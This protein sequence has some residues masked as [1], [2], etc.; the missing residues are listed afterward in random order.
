M[1]KA[2][3][4]LFSGPQHTVI[5]L[6]QPAPPHAFTAHWLAP[7]ATRGLTLERRKK[8]VRLVAASGVLPNM[9]VALQAAG[10]VGG[11]SQALKA[12]AGAGQLPMCQWLWDNIHSRTEDPYD[13]FL[14]DDALEAAAAGGHRSVCEWLLAL[15]R[16][17]LHNR[18]M[19][20]AAKGGHADLAEWLI[21]QRFNFIEDAH[22]YLQGSAHGCDLPA[23]QRAWLRFGPSLDLTKKGGVLTSTFRCPAPDWAA[24]A[25]WLE[26]QG[27]PRVQWASEV[28]VGLPD[29]G[30]ALDRLIW[31][32]GRGYPAA[33]GL[34]S[35]AALY[36]NMVVLQYLL[37][38][39][40]ML[41]DAH[42]EA[43]LVE[44]AAA[45]GQ[46]AMLQA[47]HAAGLPLHRH[48]QAA[49]GP[50]ARGGHVH[51]QTWL[52]EALGPA[53]VVRSGGLVTAAVESG[54]MELLA[55]LRHHG[56]HCD[57]GAYTSA[58]EAGWEAALE[59]LAEQGCP[60]PASG[61][62][63]VAA[64]RNGDLATATCL[65]RL[66]VP[67]GPVGSVLGA[68]AAERPID[69]IPL[70]L[71]RWLLKEGCPVDYKAFRERVLACNAVWPWWEDEVLQ[72]L[73]EY[74]GHWHPSYDH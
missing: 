60:M 9:V 5:H 6:S 25:E 26:A 19:F 13:I 57:C 17:A 45:G 64:C 61:Q 49:A 18:A 48:V 69:P 42:A 67:W 71:L 52:L 54:S 29:D 66:G 33:A 27:C 68:G 46:L 51:V 32:L 35:R 40:P 70:P 74:R 10:F 21:P 63:Y 1:N 39:M 3:A 15:G 43:E 62:P 72:L 53:A 22:L 44:A 38:R 20:A 23:L 34:V 47:L 2:T 28:A 31:L 65:R 4:E 59:W 8:L 14:A 73:E 16:L 37:A 55:W 58:A 41:G 11:A 50:A 36:G 12:A 56:C 30:E 7:G 24:K